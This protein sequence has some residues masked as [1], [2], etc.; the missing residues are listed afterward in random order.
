[1]PTELSRKLKPE[2]VPDSPRVTVSQANTRSRAPHS[3]CFPTTHQTPRVG[4]APLEF[5]EDAISLSLILRLQ[6]NKEGELGRR[7]AWL[8]ASPILH[9]HFLLPLDISTQ[10]NVTQVCSC[11]TLP[12]PSLP[13][14]LSTWT[15]EQR[16]W[17][18]N[19]GLRGWEIIV[20]DICH[21]YCWLWAGVETS[22][23]NLGGGWVTVLGLVYSGLRTLVLVGRTVGIWGMFWVGL[24]LEKGVPKR[25]VKRHIGWMDGWISGWF[26]G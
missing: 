4:W 20:D 17:C 5:G 12:F 23:V 6:G 7:T 25:P 1:M 3:E 15:G 22:A 16:A 18:P 9:H 19:P 8:T 14:P 11:P 26:N 10:T 13:H 24:T 2:R 21:I